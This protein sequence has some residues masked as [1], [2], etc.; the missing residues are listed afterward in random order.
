MQELRC[1]NPSAF[2]ANYFPNSLEIEA[3]SYLLRSGSRGE[4]GLCG[5]LSR[6]SESKALRPSS[7]LTIQIRTVPG[8]IRNVE[9]VEHLSIQRK[10][11]ALVGEGFG[12]PEILGDG[13][14]S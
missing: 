3:D 12:D 7:N 4:E 9:C 6:L 2:G 5:P 8:E 10:L 1:C 11:V 13:R 14:S